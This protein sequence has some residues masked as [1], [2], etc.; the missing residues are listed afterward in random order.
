MLELLKIII[1]PATVLLMFLTSI[2][3]FL[4]Q[5]KDLFGRLGKATIKDMTAE[6]SDKISHV[7]DTLDDLSRT[8]KQY[9]T[10]HE[11]FADIECL[12]SKLYAERNRRDLDINLMA[13][14]MTYSWPFMHRS[15]PHLLR[16]HEDLHLSLSC[17]FV[18]PEFLKNCNL[19][20]SEGTNW[21]EEATD[22]ISDLP[23]FSRKL[24]QEFGKRISIQAKTYKNLPHW[25]GVTIDRQYL[26]LGRTSWTYP[27]E[28]PKLLVGENKY[29]L[30]NNETP[31][32][33]ERI[34]LFEGWHT[35]FFNHNHHH[36][37]ID[38]ESLSQN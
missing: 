9:N 28:L 7:S 33:S 20:L 18:D 14:A 27:R 36:T 25:H 12:I 24:K 31:G 17:L 13:V 21:P 29:R 19:D 10:H 15:I 3:F 8:G 38:S 11:A 26:F 2:L 22:R 16:K 34:N 6:F 23:S 5:I 37:I 30:F 35:Y 4:K 32:G 1:W